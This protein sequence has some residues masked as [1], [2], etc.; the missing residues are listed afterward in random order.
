VRRAD[1]ILVIDQGRIVESG[2]HQQLV[3]RTGGRYRALYM[4]QF[5]HDHETQH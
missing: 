2:P 3:H 1:R 5:V 4:E